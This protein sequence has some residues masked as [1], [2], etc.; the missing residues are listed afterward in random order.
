MNESVLKIIKKY[1]KDL[2][3]QHNLEELIQIINNILNESKNIPLKKS[4]EYNS[5]YEFELESVSNN[6][7]ISILN[8]TI[9][10]QFNVS[11]T[12]LP[13]SNGHDGYRDEDIIKYKISY[14][15]KNYN[16][17]F[18]IE[19]TEELNNIISA[20]ISIDEVIKYTAIDH[21]GKL[22]YYQQEGKTG[23]NFY[24]NEQAK[25]FHDEFDPDKIY[26]CT[27]K[28]YNDFLCILFLSISNELQHEFD[29]FIKIKI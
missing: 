17:N 7:F 11:E 8:Q 24:N 16:I 15:L 19:A 21:D 2:D 20:T 18:N 14:G 10:K 9:K 5:N 3:F 28:F 25:K 29:D 1:S 27:K 6:L 13:W 23:L 12:S 22:G 4:L 26:D